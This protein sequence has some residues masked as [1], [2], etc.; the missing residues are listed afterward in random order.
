MKVECSSPVERW[1]QLL[2]QISELLRSSKALLGLWQRYKTLYS[3][4]AVAVQKQEERADR[5]LRSATD[6]DITAE[7]S[8]AWMKD[9]SV[10]GDVTSSSFA[11]SFC[12]LIFR[13]LLDLGT[14]YSALRSESESPSYS[15]E[16]QHA[17][18]L[19]FVI[20]ESRFTA[21]P[22][23]SL[24]NVKAAEAETGR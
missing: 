12:W 18:C 1:N 17:S 10:S 9:C 16:S 22:H 7:E 4:C 2:E 23:K 15:A 13:F 20:P 8:S 3:Q 6:R 5:L 21:Q 11:T 14:F 24:L 19:S